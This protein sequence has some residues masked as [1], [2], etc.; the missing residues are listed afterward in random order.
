MSHWLGRSQSA[1]TRELARNSLPSCGYQRSLVK[2]AGLGRPE[3]E[4]IIEKDGKLEGFVVDRLTEGWTPEQFAN[5]PLEQLTFQCGLWLN[6]VFGS[7]RRCIQWCLEQARH[8]R[9]YCP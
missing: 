4:A 1:I 8:H 5:P 7:T 2:G 9:N 3:R 6:L